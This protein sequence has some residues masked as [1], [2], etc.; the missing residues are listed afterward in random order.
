MTRRTYRYDQKLGKMVE[1]TGEQR[2]ERRSAHI[3]DD[4][5]PY[6]VVGPEYGKVISS[7]STHREYLRKHNLIEAGNERK[8]F[9]GT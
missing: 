9:S 5:K 1:V 2:P 6:K 8:Y 4:I 3:I 7:R